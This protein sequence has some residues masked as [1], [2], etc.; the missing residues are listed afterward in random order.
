M[1]GLSGNSSTNYEAYH[2]KL[3]TGSNIVYDFYDFYKKF[4][5]Y[6]D[7]LKNSNND[8]YDSIYTFFET[9]SVELIDYF[10]LELNI[11]TVNIIEKTEE[12]KRRM[13]IWL[14]AVATL[15][16]HVKTKL[17]GKRKTSPSTQ[18]KKTGKFA[19]IRIKSKTT[20]QFKVTKMPTYANPAK[21]GQVR[22]QKKKADG[23][24]YFATF[25][26]VCKRT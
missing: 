3:Q 11:N 16:A 25:K 1:K 26:E 15:L 5:R 20:G 24:K 2:S 23:T 7:G 4:D 14:Y 10:E 8:L 13:N 12:L 21:P 19:Y 22:V 6:I 18:W 17:G 9:T